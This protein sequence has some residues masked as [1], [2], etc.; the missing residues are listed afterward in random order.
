MVFPDLVLQISNKEF[1]KT[2]NVKDFFPAKGIFF[3]TALF[4]IWKS[5]ICAVF[6]SKIFSNKWAMGD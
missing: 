5:D 3:S 1:L 6:D 4:L 2:K